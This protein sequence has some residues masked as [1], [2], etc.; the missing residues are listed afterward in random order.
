LEVWELVQ[1]FLVDSHT[2][3]QQFAAIR[4]LNSRRDTVPE[5]PAIREALLWMAEHE[6]GRDNSVRCEARAVAGDLQLTWMARRVAEGLEVLIQELE[7]PTSLKGLKEKDAPERAKS[8]Q[9]LGQLGPRAAKAVPALIDL[10]EA[11]QDNRVCLLAIQALAGIGPASVEAVPTLQRFQHEGEDEACR[12]A[13]AKAI[14]R[15]CPSEPS[16]QDSK[17]ETIVKVGDNRR[18]GLLNPPPGDVG[19]LVPPK[20]EALS[21]EA[22]AYRQAAADV[23]ADRAKMA[24]RLQ[25]H[26]NAYLKTMPQGTYE[27]KQAL[28][29]WIN[30]QLEPR[31]LALK[32]PNT[33]AASLLQADSGHKPGIGRFQFYHMKDGVRVR[34]ATSGELPDL[35]VIAH[36]ATSLASDEEITEGEK[37]R[38]SAG[39][40][41]RKSTR[42]SWKKG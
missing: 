21:S 35:Q 6:H 7:L 17:I 1:S 37:A 10:L 27:E 36:S 12:T 11:E 4:K 33:G 42:G 24:G 19:C 39:E 28:A 22:L 20:D 18:A 30:M 23:D 3:E 2:P 14:V 5:K 16:H 29:K 32:C 25:P 15:I 40:A 9:A 31:G 38:W 41:Q 26:F 8:A 13:A 34:T